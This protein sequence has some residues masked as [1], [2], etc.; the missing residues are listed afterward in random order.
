MNIPFIAEVTELSESD[1]L[2][3]KT[4]CLLDIIPI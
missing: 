1:I 2:K 3:L 4:N